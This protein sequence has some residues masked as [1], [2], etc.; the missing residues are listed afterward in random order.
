[1]EV[2]CVI[3]GMKHKKRPTKKREL[4]VSQRGELKGFQTAIH[5]GIYMV[6]IY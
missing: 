6:A 5:P 3:F 2:G 4:T 1:M